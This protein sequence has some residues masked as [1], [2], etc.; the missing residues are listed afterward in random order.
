MVGRRLPTEHEW[1]YAASNGLIEWG[2]SV[3]EW[4]ATTFAP[5]PG[6]TPDRY[7]EYSAPWFDGQHRVL[8][9]GS[10]HAAAHAPPAL[11]QLLCRRSQ[12]RVCRISDVCD[13]SSLHRRVLTISFS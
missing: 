7:R 5:Y 6:F 12:R 10:R 3:W 2:D 9:G 1:E 13:L 11:S 8:R 4:T